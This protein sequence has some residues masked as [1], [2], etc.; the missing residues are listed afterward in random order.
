MNVDA[1]L[2]KLGVVQEQIDNLAGTG[3]VKVGSLVWTAR[4]AD[5][6][7]IPAQSIITVKE[8]A[9]VKLI[10]ELSDKDETETN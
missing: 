8:V 4:S 10:C 7:V 3:S 6:S 1:V 2:G 5:G 9:G